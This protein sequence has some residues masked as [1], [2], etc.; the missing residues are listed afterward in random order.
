MNSARNPTAYWV[1]RHYDDVAFTIVSDRETAI[2]RVDQYER[3]FDEPFRVAPEF[4]T[5]IPFHE[6]PEAWEDDWADRVPASVTVT[7][8]PP[9]AQQ[10]DTS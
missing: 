9:V 4:R 6:L 7:D 8:I 1:M 5:E 2:D 10:G 3:E